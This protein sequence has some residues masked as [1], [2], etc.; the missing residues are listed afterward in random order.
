MTGRCRCRYEVVI[1]MTFDVQKKMIG[2]NERG[3]E[4]AELVKV[5][6]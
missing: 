4:L 5:L 2:R 1:D 3:K 6:E